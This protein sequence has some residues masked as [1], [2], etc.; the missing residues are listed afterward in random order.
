MPA[1]LSICWH[2]VVVVP[3]HLRNKCEVPCLVV[4]A[5]VLAPGGA[6]LQVG[7]ACPVGSAGSGPAGARRVRL[8]R[9]RCRRRRH[10]PS[11]PQ[12]GR[13]TQYRLTVTL[14]KP[15]PPRAL[16][17]LPEW[18]CVCGGGGWGGGAVGLGTTACIRDGWAGGTHLVAIAV[19]SEG[20]G[21]GS[22]ACLWWRGGGEWRGGE[23]RDEQQQGHWQQQ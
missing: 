7:S 1:V 10:L 12:A 16:E 23:W 4:A 11:R 8:A 15:S 19:R 5:V 2:P 22:Q 6:G 3:E 18:E 14:L 17:H 20:R 9:R 13:P 21:G